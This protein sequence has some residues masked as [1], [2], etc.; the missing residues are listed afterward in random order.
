[1]KA[2]II[3]YVILIKLSKEN[4]KEQSRVQ[5]VGPGIKKRN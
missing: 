4:T 1:M 3:R 5:T 2:T